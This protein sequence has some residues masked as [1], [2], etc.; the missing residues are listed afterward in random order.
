[1]KLYMYGAAHTFGVTR[2]LLGQQE[3]ED[4]LDDGL[5]LQ[6]QRLVEGGAADHTVCRL[7]VVDCHLQS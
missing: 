2:D 1:M 4:A 7:P 6:A 3:G 5:W